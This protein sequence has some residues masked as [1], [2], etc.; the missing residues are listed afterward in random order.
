MSKS[1]SLTRLPKIKCYPS[2]LNEDG[3]VLNKH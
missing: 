1:H 2:K 3:L